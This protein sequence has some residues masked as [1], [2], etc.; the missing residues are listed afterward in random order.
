MRLSFCITC[1]NRRHQLQETLPYNLKAIASIPDV[2]LCLVNFNSQDALNEYIHNNFME[3]I[4]AK[5]LRYFYTQE[6]KYFHCSKAKNLAHRLG[7]GEVL[8]NLDADNFI[9]ETN[10]RKTLDTFSVHNNIFLHETIENKK[11]QNGTYGRIA[12]SK[13]DFYLHNGYDENLLG[14]SQH[15]MDLIARLGRNNLQLL[16]A[17]SEIKPAL[18]NDKKETL[19]N[20]KWKLPYFFYDQS[21]V[22]LIQLRKILKK[23]VNPNGMKSFYGQLDFKEY[24]HV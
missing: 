19:A 24:R 11:M 20:Q 2:E 12:L 23:P 22:L 17:Q 15:D 6:P 9:T 14:V 3:Q 16:P 4:I 10:V 7:Q 1:M 5:K 18:L 21:N 13:K 8:Y